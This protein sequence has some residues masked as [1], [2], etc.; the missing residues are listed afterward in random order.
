MPFSGK[1]IKVIDASQ[2]EVYAAVVVGV[3]AVFCIT[4]IGIFA[5]VKYDAS[6]IGTTITSVLGIFAYFTKGPGFKNITKS[7]KAPTL[8]EEQQRYEAL[9]S[10]LI[11]QAAERSPKSSPNN[12]TTDVS[13]KDLSDPE[14]VFFK[15]LGKK[16]HLL[17]N[18]DP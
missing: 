11:K 13:L 3:A 14:S 1:K 9:I 2:T 12:T 18:D 15:H 6:Y 4:G 5:A 8:E 17:Q 10:V 7:L 16:L